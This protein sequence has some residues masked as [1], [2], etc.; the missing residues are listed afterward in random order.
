MFWINEEAVHQSRR[1]ES[2]VDSTESLA[3]SRAARIAWSVR[4][5]KPARIESK[6]SPAASWLRMEVTRM[7]VPR[8]TGLLLQIRGG[9]ISIWSW[10]SV[11]SPSALERPTDEALNA[12]REG[13]CTDRRGT[14]PTQGSGGATA[15]FRK[16]SSDWRTSVTNYRGKTRRTPSCTSNRLAVSVGA[17]RS[18]LP[19]LPSMPGGNCVVLDRATLCV[20][21][22]RPTR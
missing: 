22:T 17:G 2:S 8:I 19:G 15:I 6:D 21:P 11:G 13:C 20:Q 5:G 4:P 16:T 9:S 3:N 1:G 10:Y 12:L 14:A 7:R 18:P